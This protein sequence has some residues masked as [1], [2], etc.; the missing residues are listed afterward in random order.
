MKPPRPVG[1][2]L[3]QVWDDNRAY[4]FVSPLPENRCLS[5]SLKLLATD[6]ITLNGSEA[7]FA[8]REY[9]TCNRSIRWGWELDGV[10]VMPICVDP[11][12][13]RSSSQSQF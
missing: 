7:S 13:P 2:V 12:F 11:Y 6:A 9:P 5:I 4:V 10:Q 8:G 1:Q 3:H